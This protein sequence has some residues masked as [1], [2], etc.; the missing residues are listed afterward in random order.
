MGKWQY[1]AV[2]VAGIVSVGGCSSA[3]EVAE[4]GDADTP[5][6]AS[7]SSTELPAEPPTWDTPQVGQCRQLSR[8]DIPPPTNDDPVV[9]CAK[10]HTAVTFHVGHWPPSLV[11]KVDKVDS[12]RLDGVV[13]DQCWDAWVKTV[14]GDREARA[15]TS[16]ST[17]RT[18]PTRHP[19][20]TARDGRPAIG[21]DPAGSRR[22]TDPTIGGGLMSARMVA[23]SWSLMVAVGRLGVLSSTATRS[24]SS[25]ATRGPTRQ[26]NGDTEQR[27]P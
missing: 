24:T 18:S 21:P 5:S 19:Y 23:G 25:A 3:E 2:T 16:T 26:P 12:E 15:M 17:G 7:E 13:D 8:E 10:P 6:T 9:A 22:G 27:D 20:R 4:P 11:A 1:I 14:G